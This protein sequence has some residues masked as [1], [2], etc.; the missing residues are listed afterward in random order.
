MYY[1]AG[2]ILLLG[3]L[4]FIHEFGHFYV[5]KLCGMKVKTFSIGM[6]PKLFKFTR[7]ETE[8]ALSLVPFGGYVN[9]MGQDPQE[10]VPEDEKHRS[11]SRMSLLKRFSVVIA[12]PAAN[13]IL[14]FFVFWLLFAK[15]F[16]SPSATIHF[17]QPNSPAAQAGVLAGDK[18]LSIQNAQTQQNVREL[19]DLQRFLRNTN[20]GS[21]QLKIERDGK[22]QELTLQG[23]LGKMSDSLSGIERE[24]VTLTG[25]EFQS[26]PPVFSVKKNSELSKKYSKNL[27]II[28]SYKIGE[29]NF[30]IDSI[31]QLEKAWNQSL[32][33]KQKLSLK[34]HFLDTQNAKESIPETID[35]EVPSQKDL[36]AYGFI[37]AHLM[38]TQ[39]LDES[40]AS[41]LGLQKGDI[42]KELNK[43]PVWTF[44]Q[45][46][47]RLQ[48]VAASHQSLN[49]KWI[50]DGQIK[51]G[52]FT[53]QYVENENP[54]TQLKEKKFQL[55]AM[56]IGV[57]EASFEKVKAVGFVD[58]IQLAAM[59]TWNMSAS[60]LESFVFLATGKVSMK[61]MGGPVMIGKIAGESLKLGFDS[62]MKMLAFISLNLCILNLMP[63]PVLDGGHIVLFAVEGIIRRPIPYKIIEGW[64]TVGAFMLIGLA[65][66][67]TFN[68]LSKLN[69]I[70]N[71]LKIFGK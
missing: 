34:V 32:H 3:I 66:F 27:F 5:A 22:V 47:N 12:G 23:Q 18:I 39:I 38:I 13:F 33:Q 4:V 24:S 29:E 65:L 57:G 36:N 69:V 21:F 2:I 51:E 20:E 67:V 26:Y 68:D 25:A 71:T 40:A 52:S 56:F 7:G 60:I 64:A 45:F 53:P 63:L 28:E 58:G 42:L 30:D 11:F 8:Y 48:E 61:A 44:S 31:Y 43:Q 15:G 70:S 6:G 35:L 10:N 37:P 55:G 16:P 9:I 14:T 62:F 54:I 17:V 1:F 41:K 59:K 46:K 50:R 49:L 19:S